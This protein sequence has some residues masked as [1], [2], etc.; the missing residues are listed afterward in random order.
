MGRT[1]YKVKS[2]QVYKCKM[3]GK[4]PELIQQISHA[5]EKRGV[6]APARQG[7]PVDRMVMIQ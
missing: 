1:S 7:E 3:K 4:Y 2:W 5:Q 6:K